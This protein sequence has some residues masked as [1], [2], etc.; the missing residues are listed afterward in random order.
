MH[1]FWNFLS[2]FKHAPFL[3]EKRQS[4]FMI[5]KKGKK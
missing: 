1:P 5:Y 2:K 3:K 4:N